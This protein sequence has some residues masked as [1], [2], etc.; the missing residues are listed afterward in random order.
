MKNATCYYSVW[1]VQGL[2]DSETSAADKSRQRGKEST[3]T[4]NVVMSIP[5][6]LSK[7]VTLAYEKD[8]ALR[9]VRTLQDRIAKLTAVNGIDV[10]EELDADLSTIMDLE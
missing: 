3:H 8:A 5:Q 6:M 2:Q 9:R 10:G 1:S 4:P 7:L